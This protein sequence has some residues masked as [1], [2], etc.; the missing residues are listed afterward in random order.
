MS[1]RQSQSDDLLASY[2]EF[3]LSC[4]YDDEDDPTEVT[5]F[6]GAAASTTEWLTADVESAVDLEDV[7]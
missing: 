5:V 1:V 2:P 7:R 4:R 6:P 3:G